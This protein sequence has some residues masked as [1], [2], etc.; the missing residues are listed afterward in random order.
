MKLRGNFKLLRWTIQAASFV[1]FVL[2]AVAGVCLITQGSF[3]ISCIFG[4]LQR[5][6][7]DPVWSLLSMLLLFTAVPVFGTILLGRAFCG[8]FCPVGTILDTFSRIPRV[9][10]LKPLANPVNKFALAA[11]FLTSS[12]FLKYPS[13]CTVCPIKGTCNSVSLG[14]AL[15]PTELAVLAVPIA[16]ELGGKKAWCR[17]LCPVGATLAF[18]SMRKFLGFRIDT[19]R[20]VRSSQPGTW[21]MCAQVCPT[22]AISETSFKTG[23]ISGSECITCGRCYDACRH[24]A[25]KFGK[26]SGDRAIQ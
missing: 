7:A 24:D 13:F 10:F 11:G 5:I 17:Y 12:A 16:L 26:L 4:A 8:W 3:G 23:E 20:C 18:L 15:R 14:A 2:I 25:L 21:G 6:L 1:F 19:S 9:N 22:N